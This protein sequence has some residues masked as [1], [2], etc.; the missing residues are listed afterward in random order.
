M[1]T[2]TES[3]LP[4]RRERADAARNR[5]RIL[6]AINELFAERD[7]ADVS[8]DAIA[9]R[10]GVGKPTLYRRFGDRA[11][12][13]RAVLEERERA[14]QAHLL[15]GPPPLGPGAAPLDRIVA[16]LEGYLELVDAN[17]QALLAAESS[18]PSARL[19]TGAYASYHQHLTLLLGQA[20]I[21]GPARAYLADQLLA[22]TAADLYE[23]QRARGLSPEEIR[24]LAADLAA[25]IIRHLPAARDVPGR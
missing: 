4:S 19:R 1:S 2:P 14:F 9:E 22:A 17:L 11:G 20:G 18:S 13:V 7:P 24:G 25:R 6:V 16:F 21:E 23:H 5:E 8:M 15:R 3:R 10:A 12:L